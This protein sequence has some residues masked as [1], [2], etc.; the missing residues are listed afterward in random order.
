MEFQFGMLRV[1]IMAL[2]RWKVQCD[3]ALWK[4]CGNDV[5]D[6]FSVCIVRDGY[7]GT[8][9]E[10]RDPCVSVDININDILQSMAEYLV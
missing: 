1:G 7:N 4:S 5:I 8:V 9:D 6:G 3:K 2:C 10:T